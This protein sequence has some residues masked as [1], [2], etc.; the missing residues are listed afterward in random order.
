M[1]ASNRTPEAEELNVVVV[2]SLLQLVPYLG[3]INYIVG[4]AMCVV[5]LAWLAFRRVWI[6]AIVKEAA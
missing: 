1:S 4:L 5:V 2:G 3:A 6:C